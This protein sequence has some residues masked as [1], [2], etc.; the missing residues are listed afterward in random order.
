MPYARD[1]I[2]LL[3]HPLMGFSDPFLHNAISVPHFSTK[4]SIHPGLLSCA[5]ETCGQLFVNGR[6]RHVLCL[7]V[8]PPLDLYPGVSIFSST[9]LLD[10]ID[11]ESSVL[12]VNL[13]PSAPTTAPGSPIWLKFYGPCCHRRKVSL[14]KTN[15]LSIS[16]PPH[17]GLARRI[18]DLAYPCEGYLLPLVI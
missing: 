11:T 14:G 13:P 18:S 5:S 12:P 8:S 9:L 2:H 10:L 15:H 6:K 3:L 17:H 7:P 1:R 16:R 4:F